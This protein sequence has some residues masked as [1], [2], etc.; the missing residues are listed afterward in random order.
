MKRD[1]L[2]RVLTTLVERV[3]L[4]PATRDMRVRY[5]IPLTGV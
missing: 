5:R 1:E 2:R 4:D 3:E